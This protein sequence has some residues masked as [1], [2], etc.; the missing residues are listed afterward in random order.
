[1]PTTFRTGVIEKIRTMGTSLQNSPAYSKNEVRRLRNGY[2]QLADS[3]MDLYPNRDD[4]TVAV[5]IDDGDKWNVAGSSRQTLYD[6]DTETIVFRNRFSMLTFLDRFARH[7]GRGEPRTWA[8]DAFMQAFPNE[9]LVPKGN[10]L[11]SPALA[12]S[13]VAGS[14]DDDGDGDCDEC[15]D[16]NN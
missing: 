3:L 8:R 5:E 14:D 2:Q 16:D 9:Q 7:V 12:S 13:Y 4:V 11:V 1:M 10:A 6:E 15:D